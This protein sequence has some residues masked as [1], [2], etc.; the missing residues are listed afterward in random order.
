MQTT[1]WTMPTPPMPGAAWYAGDGP[2]TADRGSE[3]WSFVRACLRG[4]WGLLRT[5]SV[6]VTVALAAAC[7]LWLV[8]GS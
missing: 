1:W 2:E 6:L 4:M 8:V 7:Q 3:I 5:A